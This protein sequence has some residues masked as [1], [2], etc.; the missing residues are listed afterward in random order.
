MLR[1][2]ACTH[3]DLYTTY[4]PISRLTAHSVA[5]SPELPP[6]ETPDAGPC[7]IETVYFDFDSEALSSS[8]RDQI[9]RNVTCMR[10]T[11]VERLHLTGY[12]D[13]QGT[14]E[15]NLALGDRRARSVMQ[16]MT[17]LGVS[18]GNLTSSSVGE[19]MAEGEDES[20][21]RRDRKVT[22]TQR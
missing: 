4:I 12:T 5:P 3:L 8:T 22:F 2:H 17:S 10:E 9:Q 20:G 6:P 18:G 7:T 19:E 13:P 14:E 21:W 1:A 15:Y 16:F 11:G